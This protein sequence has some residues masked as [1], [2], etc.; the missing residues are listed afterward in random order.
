MKTLSFAY[1]GENL[2][3]VILISINFCYLLIVML[4]AVLATVVFGQR[5]FPL[6]LGFART[7]RC[8]VFSVW[9]N[10]H[11]LNVNFLLYIYLPYSH[12]IKLSFHDGTYKLGARLPLK[13]SM[14]SSS[15]FMTFLLAVL[16]GLCFLILL[17]KIDWLKAS[18]SV[19]SCLVSLKNALGK[20]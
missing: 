3:L 2:K 20:F 12:L 9:A 15:M 5:K 17:L 8:H 7:C 11:G 14:K 4:F 16:G 10:C 1:N 18:I 13:W 19:F 6:W